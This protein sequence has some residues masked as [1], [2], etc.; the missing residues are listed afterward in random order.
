MNTQ[1][2]DPHHLFRCGICGEVIFSTAN[3]LTNCVAGQS[4]EVILDV[5]YQLQLIGHRYEVHSQRRVHR[6]EGVPLYLLRS[7]IKDA[8][9]G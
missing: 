8:S 9:Y 3:V 2:D 4:Q 7:S 1:A 6:R 5:Q